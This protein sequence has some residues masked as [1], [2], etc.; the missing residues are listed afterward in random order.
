MKWLCRFRH[1]WKT[2]FNYDPYVPRWKNKFFRYEQYTYVRRCIRCEKREYS[3]YEPFTGVFWDEGRD[4][5]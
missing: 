4:L 1:K 5:G 2:E 3:R